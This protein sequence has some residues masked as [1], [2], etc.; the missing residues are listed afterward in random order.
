MPAAGATRSVQVMKIP[1]AML[2]YW[3][4]K[5]AADSTGEEHRHPISPLFRLKCALPGTTIRR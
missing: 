2:C 1:A 3:L 5:N 4:G